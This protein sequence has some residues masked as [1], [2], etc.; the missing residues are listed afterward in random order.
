MWIHHN[1]QYRRFVESQE[2]LYLLEG[3]KITIENICLH[4]VSDHERGYEI[5]GRRNAYSSAKN[6]LP[7]AI[8]PPPASFL[9][10][11][12]QVSNFWFETQEAVSY[13]I[14]CVSL[15]SRKSKRL[16]DT[17]LR[18]LLLQL[19]FRYS[20]H[21]PTFVNM[22]RDPIA[23]FQSHYTFMRFGMNKGRGENDPKLGS[24][25]SKQKYQETIMSIQN[26]RMLFLKI[27]LKVAI[28]V[29]S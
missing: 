10:G 6:A 8:L 17:C 2:Q 22:I 19:I 12:Q 13:Y 28:L 23:W 29:Q 14:K 27:C 5:Y 20:M 15:I 4:L 3:K 18:W 25:S 1:A 7:R 9:D 11:F 21:Q 26:L 24:V 16:P